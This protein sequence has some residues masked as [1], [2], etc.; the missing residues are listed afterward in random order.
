[1]PASPFK[2]ATT[3]D[4]PAAQDARGRPTG[5]NSTEPGRFVRE[6]GSPVMWAA[7]W[8]P[9]A[10]GSASSGGEP[11]GCSENRWTVLVGK[12]KETWSWSARRMISA[13]KRCL[14][15]NSM[16]QSG[17]STKQYSK[18]SSDEAEKLLR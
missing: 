15:R 17:H 4:S 9:I 5:Q 12:A 8:R 18:M 1:M 10:S 14:S 13:S 7:V 6:N 16:D 11:G 2:A 3:A